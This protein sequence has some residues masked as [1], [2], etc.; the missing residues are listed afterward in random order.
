MSTV[1][2]RSKLGLKANELFVRGN[3]EWD[4][5]NL[6]SAFRLFLSA[7]K[8]GDEGAQVNLGFFY[9]TGLGVRPN[10]DSAVRWY[11]RAYRQG[12]A[13]GAANI[14]TIWRDEGKLL[15]ALA[16]FRKAVALGN[17]D[18]HLEIAKIYLRRGDK[19]SAMYHLKR[20]LT[21]TP[22]KVT[23][24][25]REDAGRLLRGLGRTGRTGS[26]RP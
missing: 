5:G 18:A 20:T 12:S 21:A 7:A 25:S 16:W 23:E 19:K 8:A 14:G 17:S 6:G 22:N 26:R 10:R 4:R 15:R 2:S 24:D 3:E 1:S 9:D 13:E 11:R